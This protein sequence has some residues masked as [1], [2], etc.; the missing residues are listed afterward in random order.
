MQRHELLEFS[1]SASQVDELACS[2]TLHLCNRLFSKDCGECLHTHLQMKPVFSV[3]S[4]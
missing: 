4:E 3:V 2:V 1:A